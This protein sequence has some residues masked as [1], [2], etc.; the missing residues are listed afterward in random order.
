LRKIR[1]ISDGTTLG[2]VR[3]DV[4]LRRQILFATEHPFVIAFDPETREIVRVVHGARDMW[5]VFR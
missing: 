3:G 2:H 5:R 1:R 4:A